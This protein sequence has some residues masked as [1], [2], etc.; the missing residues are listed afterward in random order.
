MSMAC[1]NGSVTQY[2][3]CNHVA[4]K[5][6]SCIP[7]LHH[8][9]ILI[10]IQQEEGKSLIISETPLTSPLELFHPTAPTV[11]TPLPGFLFLNCNQGPSFTKVKLP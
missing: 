4:C 9:T 8:H 1:G 10:E 3:V 2:V 6:A 5:P 7:G 11:H